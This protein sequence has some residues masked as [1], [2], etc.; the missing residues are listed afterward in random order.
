[1]GERKRDVWRLAIS[2]GIVALVTLGSGKGE[3][4]RERADACVRGATKPREKK[5][6]VFNN[7]LPFF[8][9]S[10]LT[11]RSK[12]PHASCFCFL[13]PCSCYIERVVKV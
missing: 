13:S 9:N 4:E 1:M 5:W 7:R 12:R 6:I 11:V 3:G 10:Y 2:L 8:M